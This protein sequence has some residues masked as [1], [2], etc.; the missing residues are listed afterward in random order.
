[1]LRPGPAISSGLQMTQ[2]PT[3]KPWRAVPS[4]LWQPVRDR[5]QGTS[6]PVAA[7]GRDPQDGGRSVTKERDAKHE[8][9]SELL[10]G[11]RSAERDSVAAHEAASVAARAV[12]AAA[13]AENAAVGA[14][15]A[16]REATEA[17]ARAKE[18]AER[19][20][21]AAAQAAEAAQLAS[22][23]TED[24]Q[25]RADETVVEA[26]RAETKARDRFHEAEAD[27]FPKA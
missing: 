13:A 7:G 21:V 27:G 1:M 12:T 24:D 5:G 20:R 15:T 11:W 26:D 23:T 17:A 22:A 3:H 10:A 9:A 16:A 19:A 6:P 25:A 2:D 14:E 8:S 18:A 4:N